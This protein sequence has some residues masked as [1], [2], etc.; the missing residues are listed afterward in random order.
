MIKN[1]NELSVTETRKKLLKILDFGLEESRPSNVL[2]SIMSLSKDIL[3]IKDKNFDLKK[4]KRIFVISFGKAGAD[5]A[6]FLEDLLADKITEG[7]SIDTKESSTEIIKHTIGT[8]PLSS[9]TNA[10]FTEYAKS[11]ISDLNEDDL[12]LVAISGGGSALFSAP[13]EM[14]G[15]VGVQMFKDLTKAGA[16]INELNIVR[17]HLSSVKGGNLAKSIYPAKC[18]TLIFSDVPGND[19][20]IIAS[21]TTVKDPSTKKDAMN[22]LNK[23]NINY[24]GDLFETPKEDKYF[25]NVFNILVS[26]NRHTLNSMKKKAEEFGINTKILDKDINM[27]ANDLGKFLI[28]KTKHKELLLAA[29]ETTVKITGSG[30]G[31]R[32]QQSALAALR[33]IKNEDVIISCASDGYDFTEA[34]GA[35]ADK[36][37]LEKTKKENLEIEEYLKK[38][39]SFNFFEKIKDQIITGKTGLNVSDLFM[40]YKN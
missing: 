2:G 26:S 38:N 37:A 23:Y 3:K 1:L 11:M 8:H 7:V 40:S 31:G 17:K 34:A 10:D 19:L 30:K 35:I 14:E 6:R 9:K 27:D 24:E 12:V 39:D 28:E 21:G 5:S 13:Y 32:N 25:E 33:H 22:I 18:V 4:H 15:I 16:P 36:I 20:S 29:G